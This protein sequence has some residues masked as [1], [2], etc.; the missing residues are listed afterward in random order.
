M[1][2]PRWGLR[3]TFVLGLSVLLGAASPFETP[4][5]TPVAD[6]AQANDVAQVRTLLRQGADVN[7]P[8]PD[9]LTALHWAALNDSQEIVDVLLYAGANMEPLTRVGGYT[10]LHLA[11]RSG[12]AAVV[13]SL[14]EHGADADR[15]TSTGVT[16][17]HFA[18]QANDAEVIRALVEHGA[19]IDAPDGF[20][21][22]TPLV[23]AASRDA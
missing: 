22:R 9:G 4:V 19:D 23:F 2:K 13:R 3:V 8:Q 11:A 10:P 5:E 17:L 15:W 21:S 12:H 18:A 1:G 16:A 20:Q 6:A 14:L 7:A